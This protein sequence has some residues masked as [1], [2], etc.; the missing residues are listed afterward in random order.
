MTLNLVDLNAKPISPVREFAHESPVTRC[1][2]HGASSL[3][4]RECLAVA[5]RNRGNSSQG[6]KLASKL[7]ESVAPDMSEDDQLRALF[8]ML[9]SSA[10]APTPELHLLAPSDEARILAIFELARRYHFYVDSS[11][12]G[13]NS[14]DG[15]SRLTRTALGRVGSHWRNLSVEWLGFVP[16]YTSRP[17]NLCIVERGV[18]TH[19]NIDP[20]ELFA[21][22]LA[23][24][25]QMIILFHN[26]PSGCMTPSEADYNLTSRVD[27]ICKKLGIRLLSHWIV[28][29]NRE[30]EVILESWG[31]R[32]Q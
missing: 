20:A 22:I 15:L 6:V 19:V 11:K 14:R 1:T 25:P 32:R 9:E 28:S 3:S 26:H 21:R 7:L 27:E 4:L 10:S 5:F 16:V 24:R 12:V 2:M 18:R 29:G 31:G 13:S 8:R 30:S 17:G 23:L